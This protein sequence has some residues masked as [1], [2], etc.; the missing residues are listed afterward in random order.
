MIEKK[1]RAIS[2]RLL[3]Q[4]GTTDGVVKVA[5]AT[6]FKVEQEVDLKSSTQPVLPLAVKDIP[7]ETTLVLGPRGKPLSFKTNVSLYLVADAATI[8]ASTQVKPNVIEQDII[9]SSFEE[10]PTTARRSFLVDILGRGY[11]TKNP[12]PVR[13]SDGSVNIGTVNAEIETQLSHKDNDPDAGDVADSVRIGNGVNELEINSD[14][15]ALVHDQDTH[16][17]LDALTASSTA[18]SDQTQALLQA[19]FD[20]T[21]A[22][23]VSL[24]STVQ[25]EFDAT[26]T[27]L[28]TELDATQAAIASLETTV[29]SESDAT[30]SLLTSEFNETQ[31]KLDTLNSTVQSE[32]DATQTLLQTEFDATQTLLQTE[33]DATQVKQ[34]TGNSSLASLDGKFAAST[35]TPTLNSN[36]NI[37]RPLPYEPQ[38]YSSTVVGLV[39]AANPTDVFTIIGSASKVVRIHKIRVSGTTT[40]GSPIKISVNLVKRSTADTAGTSTTPS[41]VPHDSDNAAGTAVTRAYTANPTLGTSVG[42]IR[43]QS[44]SVQAAGMTEAIDWDFEHLGQPLVLRGVAQNLAVNFNG[45]SITGSVIS[46]SIEWSEV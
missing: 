33:F 1:L 12:L 35:T 36:A 24:E 9:R 11:T 22:A 14:K 2:P 4:N 15:E 6:L 27:L 3:T 46:I 28:Q 20:E 19:E 21:Q 39:L 30:Q 38:T 40:S 31:T 7:D 41:V 42:V 18:E 34:D 29:Q 16:D 37:V 45:T 32:S 44:T 23:I 5:D 8:E 17:K 43:A 25:T 26:Q 10:A 13:L